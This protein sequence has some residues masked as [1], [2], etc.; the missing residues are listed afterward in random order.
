M[1]QLRN[2]LAQRQKELGN[3]FNPNNGNGQSQQ[4]E[5]KP[6]RG[7]QRGSDGQGSQR[8]QGGHASRNFG[9][10][11][12]P[13]RGG[14]AAELVFGEQAEM[15]PERLAFEELPEGNGGE[16]GE[17]RG[18]RAANPKVKQSAPLTPATGS[19][20]NGDQAAGWDEGAMRPRNRA[21]V[22]RYFDSK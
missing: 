13:S 17:L 2:A 11:G 3:K 6:Q 19:G 22:Q 20:A 15:D 7:P 21:L 18:L 4:G 12:E 8:Q 16:A 5:G 10:D 9:G 14:E 1:N